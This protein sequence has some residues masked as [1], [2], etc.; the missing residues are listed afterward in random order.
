MKALV[1]A[2]SVVALWAQSS[3]ET[4]VLEQVQRIYER[5]GRITFSELYNS[6]EF[7]DE[8]RAFLGRL[9]EIFFAV[10][11]FL[12]AEL[13]STGAVP[14]RSEIARS[15]GIGLQ[16]V[17]LLIRVMESDRRVPPLFTRDPSSG[18]IASLDLEN[19]D[20]F[21]AARG[22]DVRMTQWEGR[23]LPSFSL[24]TLTGETLRESEL[25]GRHAFLYFWFT[26]CP[27]CVRIAPILSRLADRYEPRG[28]R[29]VG[30]NADD[31]LGL[32]TS[33]ESRVEYLRGQGLGFVNVNL[34]EATRDRFGGINVYPTIFL[35]SRDGTISRHMV[36]FQSEERLV[37]VI[38]E[39]LGR[40]T[41]G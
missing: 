32:D 35:V 26:G 18:E 15:F 30:V 31:I 1:V 22:A 7:S 38:E 21:V 8:E 16:S 24:T 13:E 36:N 2:L 33:N 6:D 20:R 34:D 3:V 10:P 19:I 14:T 17:E 23:P 12:K 29:F 27:P 25:R 41:D 9:Y 37:S 5:D 4:R 39:L 28:L 40:G 11:A